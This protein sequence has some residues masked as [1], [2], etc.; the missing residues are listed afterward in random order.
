MIQAE[1]VKSLALLASHDRAGVKLI[2]QIHVRTELGDDRHIHSLPDLALLLQIYVGH[3]PNDDVRLPIQMLFAIQKAGLEKERI[4]AM[5][6]GDP[7]YQ[8]GQKNLVVAL[9]EPDSQR[10]LFIADKPPALAGFYGAT[11]QAGMFCGIFAGYLFL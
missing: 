3:V 10:V 5:G 7:R 6:R 11:S 8:W 2:G 9:P 1:P 4:T